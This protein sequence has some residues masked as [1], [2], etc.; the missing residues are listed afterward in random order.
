MKDTASSV[1]QNNL[2]R[3]M[4]PR[5]IAFVGGKAVEDCIIATRKSGFDGY[6]WVVHPK[7]EELAG[8]KCVPSLANLPEPPDATLIAVSRERTIDVVAELNAMGAGGAVS[9]VGEFAETGEDGAALQARLIEAAGDLALV[10]PNCLGVMNM[11]DQAAVWGGNNVFEPVT[12][13]GV[14]LISQSGYVAYSIT[15]VEKALPLG[16]TIS[17]GNQAVLNVADFIDVLL[18]DPR[19]RAIG[20]YL[21]GIVDVAALSR[22]ALRAIDK[23]IPIVALKAGGTQESSELT[24]SHSGTLAVTNELWSALFCRLGIVE[25]GSPKVLVE[26]LKLL[27]SPKLP[28]GTRVVAA[29]NSG[30]YAAMIGEKG[31]AFGLEFPAPRD[32]AKRALRADVPDLVSLLNPLD[33]NLP[34]ASMLRSETSDVGLGH[35]MA[36]DVD[37]LIYFID[38]PRQD[39]VAQVWWP[40]LEGLIQLNARIDQLVVVASVLPDGLPKNLRHQLTDAGLICLQ[41]L[42]DTLAAIAAAGKYHSSRRAVLADRE[43]R[44]LSAPAPQ[45]KSV[46]QVDEAEGKAALE[47]CGLTIPRGLTGSSEDVIANAET[48]GY[49]LAV[50]LLSADLAHKNHAGAVHLNV[51]SKLALEEAVDAIKT[52]VG[53]YDPTLQTDRFLIER[54]VASPLAEF[55]VGV[56]YK[57]GL[58]HALIIGRG[59]TDVEELRDFAMLLLPVS[60]VQIEDALRRLNLVRKLRLEQQDIASLVQVV[61]Q[62]AQFSDQYRERLVELDVNPIILDTFGKCTAVDAMMRIRS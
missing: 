7:Y 12:G 35:L 50:K 16:Y 28:R 18:D 17:M 33:W 62:V 53:A 58:G 52:S 57:P 22:A 26:T 61:S 25:V 59:G 2:K 41:G 6:I 31:R 23:G 13:D 3:L 4:K 49:P 36:D 55:I 42:D 39:D 11:F 15:N 45:I 60:A 44:E 24:H 51:G 27:G 40:T 46:I 43:S 21:E 9:I 34:W 1:R 10:G 14:A 20:L 38:W 54:M 30:G 37:L 29:T 32:A 5:H 56:S 48:L 8:I 19:V 47:S